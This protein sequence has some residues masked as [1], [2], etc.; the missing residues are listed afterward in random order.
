M[1]SGDTSTEVEMKRGNKTDGP[2]LVAYVRA[3][4]KRQVERAA[5]EMDVS[6]SQLITMAL[7]QYLEHAKVKS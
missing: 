2:R 7:R 3:D 5:A 6:L 4:L 1:G